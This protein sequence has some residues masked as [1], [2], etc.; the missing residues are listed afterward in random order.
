M[1][2]LLVDNFDSYTYNL[3]Q[4][5]AQVN[6]TEPDVVSNN[7]EFGDVAWDRYDNIVISP[8]PGH[9]A[10]ERDFGVNTRILRSTGLPVLG[11]CLG[12]EGLALS[13]GGR[14]APAPAPRHG[15]VS[16]IRHNDDLLFQGIPTEFDAVRYHSLA[17][18][19]P[20][21]DPL[22]AIAWSEDEVVMALRHRKLPRW[23]VQFHP[24]SIETSYGRQLLRNFRDLSAVAPRPAAPRERP[25]RSPVAVRGPQSGGTGPQLR[26]QATVRELPFEVDTEATF[27]QLYG[28]SR[29][30]FWLDSSWVEPGL[31]RF[32]Y[33]GDASGPLAEVAAANAGSVFDGLQTEL[34]RR[35]IDAPNLPFDFT[36]GYVGYFGYELHTESGSSVPRRVAPTP[37][38]YWLFCDRFLAVDHLERRTWLVA[39]AI[40]AGT[41]AAAAAWL[42]S[43][44]AALE[45]VAGQSDPLVVA[46]DTSVEPWLTRDRGQYLADIA[47]CREKLRAG[48]SYEINLTNSA[49]IPAA[50]SGFETYRRLRRINPAPYA[51]YLRLGDIEIA[52]SSPER[53]L[54]VTPDGT[55]EA[56]P[57]KGTAARSEV[58]ELDERLRRRLA[59]DRKTRAENLMIVDLIRNDLGRVCSIGSVHVPVLMAVES[60]R[61][62]HQLVSTV[63]GRL[64][65]DHDVVDCVRACFPPG[66]MTGAPKLRTMEIID[67]LE[68]RAR[69]VYSGALGF[70]GCNGAADLNVVIRTMVLVNGSWHIGAG[71]AVVLDSDPVDEFEEMLLKA[72]APMRALSAPRYAVSPNL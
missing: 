12:H 69:G 72:A 31:S 66:S 21:P 40:D 49:E 67:A 62:V 41:Q 29:H 37:D 39:L 50:G 56:K 16:R 63:R 2:T 48:E 43:T 3:F 17:V 57:I 5:L 7:V 32:S 26:F 15:H 47:E 65:P 14:V 23:G 19:E 18:T 36:G 10:R 9:P 24:E 42:E 55:A 70:L 61:T 1:R 25:A 46:D 58:P 28:A 38:A 13:A 64:L 4:L 34:A 68:H 20:L 71:G 6:G 60:Y 51:A 54:R 59:A 52:C 45:P 30:A 27:A 35:E 53:F 44:A 33:L 11:V 22:A 8:G